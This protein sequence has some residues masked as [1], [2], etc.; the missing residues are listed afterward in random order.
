MLPGAP[1]PYVLGE[2]LEII[3]QRIGHSETFDIALECLITSALT[4]VNTTERNLAETCA[5]N[6]RAL[7]RIRAMLSRGEESPKEQDDILLAISFLYAAE[8]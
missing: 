6:S 4:Y 1:E 8:V 2:W 7:A 5:L 3:P